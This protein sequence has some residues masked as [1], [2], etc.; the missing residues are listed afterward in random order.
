MTIRRTGWAA[1]A[2]VVL[3]AVPLAGCGGGHPVS[4]GPFGNGGD[5]ATTLCGPLSRGGVFTAGSI[6][7]FRNSGPTAVIDRV[8]LSHLRGLQLLADY[9]VPI[10]GNEGYG[11][12]TGYPPRDLSPGVLW[13]QRQRADG[14]RI[15]PSHR[16]AYID[17]TSEMV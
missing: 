8:S 6:A 7:A 15:P 12:L 10:A 3:A 1:F 5:T 4:T 13:S 16:H 17:Y 2:A 9:A 11:N 14:A